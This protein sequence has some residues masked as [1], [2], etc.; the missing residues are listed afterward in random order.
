MG[1]REALR[2]ERQAQLTPDLDITGRSRK[3]VRSGH[4][5]TWGKIL[6]HT[7]KELWA[8][9]CPNFPQKIS[10]MLPPYSQYWASL[11]TEGHGSARTREAST[12]VWEE[13]SNP[14]SLPGNI[15]WDRRQRS[16]ITVDRPPDVASASHL[17]GCPSGWGLEVRSSE[18]PHGSPTRLRMSKRVIRTGLFPPSL[19]PLP[20]PLSGQVVHQRCLEV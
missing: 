19:P 13:G 12:G 5:G 1:S 9:A 15:L 6:P 11:R 18:K 8:Y 7:A 20:P 3:D 17:Q 14:V 2:Q 16:H 4:E 10:E